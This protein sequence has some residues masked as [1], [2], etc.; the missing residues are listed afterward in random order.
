MKALLLA[1]LVVLSAACEKKPTG[2]ELEQ[3]REAE[4]A[5]KK[6]TPKPGE[7]MHPKDYQNPLQG[8]KK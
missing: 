4:E 8:P 2:E 7:W 5:K 1:L 3:L 6:P